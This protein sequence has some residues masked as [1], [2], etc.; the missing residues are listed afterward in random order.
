MYIY[1][2]QEKVLK[3]TSLNENNYFP[4]IFLLIYLFSHVLNKHITGF[5]FK[6][7]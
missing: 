6:Y 2:L 3:D 7:N 5:I 1:Y 4:T